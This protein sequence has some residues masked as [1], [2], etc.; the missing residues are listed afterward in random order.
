[1]Q[2]FGALI[3]LK[4]YAT[5]IYNET[6]ISAMADTMGSKLKQNNEENY[7]FRINKYKNILKLI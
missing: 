4:K 6:M 2:S 5:I 7:N 3:L 1:L